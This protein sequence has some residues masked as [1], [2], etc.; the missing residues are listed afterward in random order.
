MR[1]AEELMHWQYICDYRDA[2]DPS[3]TPHNVEM[4]KLWFGPALSPADYTWLESVVRT[5]EESQT[6]KGEKNA[7]E[8]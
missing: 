6:E 4:A 8:K 2:D 5:R 1:L 7:D 3:I